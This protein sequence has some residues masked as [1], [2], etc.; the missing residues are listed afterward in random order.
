MA[1]DASEEDTS[2]MSE[3]FIVQPGQGRH[4]DLGTFEALVLA[5]SAETSAEYTLLQVQGEPPEFGPPLHIHRD[6][7][8]AFYVLEGEYRMYVGERQ[9]SCP[10]GTFVYVPRDTPHTFKVI[11]PGP[12]R[13][14]VLFSP[15]AMLGYFEELS[16]AQAAGEPTVELLEAIGGRNNVEVVGPV[17]DTYL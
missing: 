17:P 1:V 6:C 9:Q 16:A 14:L 5:T 11:S 13:K 10:P 12:G 4:L 8:E 7:A 2:A 15:A 3:A